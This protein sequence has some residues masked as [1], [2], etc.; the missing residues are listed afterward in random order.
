MHFSAHVR[1]ALIF[2][3]RFSR[4]K[5][6]DVSISAKSLFKIYGGDV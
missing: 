3:I 6:E 1:N 2:H 5:E 4:E